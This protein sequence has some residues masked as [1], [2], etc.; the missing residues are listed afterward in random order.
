MQT[1]QILDI[2]RQAMRVAVLLAA[3][4]LLFGLVVGVLM[5]VLQAV[6]QITE[7]TLAVV[8]KMAAMLLALIIFSPWM[9]DLLMDFTTTL[10][11]SIPSM[12]R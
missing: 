6:T 12:I 2:T 7:T 9:L 4:L 11:E 1:E 3:P 10:F 5:N 8:P